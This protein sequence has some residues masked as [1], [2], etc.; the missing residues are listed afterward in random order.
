MSQEQIEIKAK[1]ELNLQEPDHLVTLFSETKEQVY[2][3]TRF[4][5]TEPDSLIGLVADR[6]GFLEQA[7]MNA[8]VCFVTATFLGQ[9]MLGKGLLKIL[10]RVKEIKMGSL[11]F[12][13]TIEQLLQNQAFGTNDLVLVQLS[14]K[15]IEPGTCFMPSNFGLRT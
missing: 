6:S 8:T 9:E 7:R 15:N 5:Q 1:P 4:I 14:V 10:G 2:Y 11:A 3:S 13:N 12:K